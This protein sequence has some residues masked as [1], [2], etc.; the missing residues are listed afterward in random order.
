MA[1]PSN[2]PFGNLLTGY[3]GYLDPAAQ[4]A[5]WQSFKDKN[6]FATDPANTDLVALE[7]FSDFVQGTFNDGLSTL[8]SPEEVHKRQLLF[9]LYDLIIVMMQSIQNTVA[10][11][12]DNITFLGKY[13]GV[14]TDQMARTADSFYMSHSLSTA[15]VNPATG[16]VYIEDLTKWKLGYSNITM[17]EYLQTAIL[18]KPDVGSP[19]V[20][21][22]DFKS[23]PQFS[24]PFGVGNFQNTLAFS[25]TD[26]SITLT[27]TAQLDAS[28]FIPVTVTVPFGTATSFEDKM[29]IATQGFTDLY[30]SVV[31]S[32]GGLLVSD[33]VNDPQQQIRIPY[34]VV[35]DSTIY[36]NSPYTAVGSDEELAG[37]A[38]ASQS[39]SAKNSLLQQFLENARS[40]REIIANQ[41]DSQRTNL[42][43]SENAIATSG[44]ILQA[45]IKQ[46]S[47]ILDSIYRIA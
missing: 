19:L 8:L 4:S 18:A 23:V 46:L 2:G 17:N 33:F 5:L 30:N 42:D 37:Q 1:L 14:Y 9:N 28:T 35:T 13:Q 32:T 20:L 38:A 27:F 47:T 3:F 22:S 7:K 39:R 36:I 41:A 16:K 24:F 25:A 15:A 34:G 45:T 21:H 43:Q 11:T 26:S 31:P 10:V 12:G 29:A 40:R 44:N 6:G